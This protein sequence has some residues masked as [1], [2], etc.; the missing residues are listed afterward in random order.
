MQLAVEFANTIRHDGHGGVTDELADLAGFADWLTQ[1]RAQ[2]GPI[3]PDETMRVEVTALRQAVR[4]LFAHA[5]R[6]GPASPADL[7][8][9]PPFEPSLARLNAAAAGCPV[10][11]RLD[12]RAGAEPVSRIVPTATDPARVLRAG[13]ARAAIDLLAGPQREQ[14]RACTAPRCVRYFVKEHGRQEWCKPSCANRARAARH[15]HRHHP[16]ASTR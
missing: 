11:V 6:P 1:R 2:L 15:Y 3:T 4:A 16:D 13:L 12:W 14:L 8:R 7:D 9:L 10:T 5:V